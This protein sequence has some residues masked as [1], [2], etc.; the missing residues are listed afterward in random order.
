MFIRWISSLVK[1][2]LNQ[3]YILTFGLGLKIGASLK[4]EL[5]FLMSPGLIN[6]PRFHVLLPIIDHGEARTFHPDPAEIPVPWGCRETLGKTKG[7]PFDFQ[8][9]ILGILPKVHRL[10]DGVVNQTLVEVLSRAY[11]PQPPRHQRVSQ[12]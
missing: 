10:F 7:C 1:T 6:Q 12:L 4:I 9:V 11:Q 5:F 3:A 8:G 2:R